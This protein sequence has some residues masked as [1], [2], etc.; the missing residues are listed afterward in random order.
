MDWAKYPNFSADEFRCKCGCGVEAMQEPFIAR[1]QH[2]RLIYKR[3]MRI[4]SGY[5][6]PKHPVEARKAAPG[7]HSEG[8]AADIAVVGRDAYDL[9]K[10]ATQHGFTGIGVQQKGESRFIHLDDTNS[11]I[12]PGI[13]SY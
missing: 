1:L 7:V 6:C 2:L 9:V 10:L 12:R 3:P 13:W 11:A 4:T 8:R 5:R